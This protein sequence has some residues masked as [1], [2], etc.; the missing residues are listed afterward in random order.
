MRVALKIIHVR[1]A[2]RTSCSTYQDSAGAV[3]ARYLAQRPALTLASEDQ[4]RRQH[5]LHFTRVSTDLPIMWVR[6][7]RT[8]I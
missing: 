1:S 3:E 4:I 2:S 8:Y 6:G 7:D 5:G